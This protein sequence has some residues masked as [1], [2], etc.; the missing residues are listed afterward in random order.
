M[1]QYPLYFPDGLESRQTFDD[2]HTGPA[3]VLALP[4]YHAGSFFGLVIVDYDA[5]FLLSFLR[6]YQMTM[7]K[8][9]TFGLVANNGD[10]IHRGEENCSALPTGALKQLHCSWRF[11]P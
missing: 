11:L 4:A 6:D 7:S 8:N 10:W 9:I 3:L 5:C 2:P 1:M